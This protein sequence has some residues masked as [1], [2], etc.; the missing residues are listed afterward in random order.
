MKT[1]VDNPMM[2]P[3][4]SA[5]RRTILLLS[6]GEL[7]GNFGYWAE[8]EIN[9]AEGFL[10]TIEDVF[11]SGTTMPTHGSREDFKEEEPGK[12]KEKEEEEKDKDDNVE[13]SLDQGPKEKEGEKERA[14]LQEMRVIGLEMTGTAQRQKVGMM[15]IGPMK[16]RQ[17]G[18]TK[19]GVWILPRKR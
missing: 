8:D 3:S 15:A 10:D 19:A 14:T 13:D 11:G 7:E 9:G 5:R 6:E 18:N 2:N 4:R 1:A 17:R 16:M 12:E